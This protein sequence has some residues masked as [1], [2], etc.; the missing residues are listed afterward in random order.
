MSQVLTIDIDYNMQ[1]VEN[2]EAAQEGKI[3]EVVQEVGAGGGFSP[4]EWND[5]EA[6]LRGD[7]FAVGV[8]SRDDNIQHDGGYQ[9]GFDGNYVHRHNERVEGY[10]PWQPRGRPYRDPYQFGGRGGFGGDMGMTLAEAANS[11]W[12]AAAFN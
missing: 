1:E 9:G 11:R 4:N 7:T 2:Q 12:S 8:P 3:Q 5:A 10:G 6:W